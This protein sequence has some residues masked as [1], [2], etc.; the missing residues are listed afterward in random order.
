MSDNGKR[1]AVIRYS[2]SGR[3]RTIRK[4]LTLEE[5]QAFCSG[6]GTSGKGWFYGFTEQ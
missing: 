6:E 2:V 3:R 4:N 5:A 1:Y